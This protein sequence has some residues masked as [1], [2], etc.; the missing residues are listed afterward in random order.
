[1]TAWHELARGI[2]T[3]GVVWAIVYGIVRIVNGPV[4]HALLRIF[5]LRDDQT[6]S[7]GPGESLQANLA[8][9]ESRVSLLER[10]S[11][12]TNL[13]AAAGHAAAEMRA[14]A[15]SAHANRVDHGSAYVSGVRGE[16]GL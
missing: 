9:L 8:Q 2:T 4:T 10:A 13:L 14:G 12:P 16:R 3:I 7:L 5:D 6:V 1:M 15:R 11:D